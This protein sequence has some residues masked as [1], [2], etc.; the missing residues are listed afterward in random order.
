MANTPRADGRAGR[1]AARG[2]HQAHRPVTGPRRRTLSRFRE[3][4]LESTAAKCRERAKRWRACPGVGRKTANVVL[5]TAFGQPTIAVDTHIFRVANRTGL[6]PGK[7]SARS[8][9]EA[10]EVHARRIPAGRA[11]LADPARALRLPRAQARLPACLIRD[12]CEFKGKTEKGCLIPS[13]EQVRDMFF[14]AWRKYRAGEPLAGIESLA[15]DVILLH[16]EYHGVLACR[17]SSGRRT[18][19]NERQ[20]VPAHEPARGARGAALDR[21]AAGHQGRLS[22]E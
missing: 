18:T 21:P 4:L 3:I 19:R 9:A 15:L 8:G 17:T 1:R 5:N 16:P 13:R 12:L 11:P 20:S 7:D 22:K 2:I 6:A 10:A 14:A